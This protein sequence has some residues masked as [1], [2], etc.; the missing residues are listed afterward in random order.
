MTW[1]RWGSGSESDIPVPRDWDGDGKTDIAVYRGAGLINWFI[2]PSKTG[3]PYGVSFGGALT[4]RPV[5]GDFDKDG[6][7]DIAIYRKGT[8][9]WYVVPSSGGAVTGV[10][11]GG[12]A[13]LPVT[14]NR[15]S[16]F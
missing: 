13:F 8:G 5:P 7:A 15:L 2:I 14:L 11:W 6:K 4:D 9:A 12:P 10:G 16:I 1:I 3:I